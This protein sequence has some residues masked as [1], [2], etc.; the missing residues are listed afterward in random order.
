[1]LH[2]TNLQVMR[3]CNTVRAL[4]PFPITQAPGDL[5]E[6][7][8]Q[9]GLQHATDHGLCPPGCR[10]VVMA[11]NLADGPDTLPVLFTRVC[12]SPAIV[13]LPLQA[14]SYLVSHLRPS[15]P[16][17]TQL[18]PLKNK[19]CMSS[20]G[21]PTQILDISTVKLCRV[22]RVCIRLAKT[23]CSIVCRRLQLRMKAL[24]HM[25]SHACWPASGL[26]QLHSSATNSLHAEACC[27]KPT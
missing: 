15:L 10:V 23:P 11:E 20:V 9:E 14:R 25:P 18:H 26:G 16:Q 5:L 13:V 27:A 3:R 4:F 22:W 17:V 21:V 12:P 24:S 6:A 1:M 8:L 7:P 19:K 2:I